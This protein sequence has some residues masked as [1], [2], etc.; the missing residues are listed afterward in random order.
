MNFF[1]LIKSRWVSPSACEQNIRRHRRHARVH[2]QHHV[3]QVL[4]NLQFKFKKM[5]LVK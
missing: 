2:R 5:R 4:V 3:E 1:F